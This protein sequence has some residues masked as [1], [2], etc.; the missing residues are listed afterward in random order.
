MFAQIHRFESS[1]SEEEKA[2]HFDYIFTEK[3]DQQDIF[4]QTTEPLISRVLEGAPVTIFCYGAI[5]S[6]TICCIFLLESKYHF[7]NDSYLSC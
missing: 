2:F 6:G 5:A 3:T 1:S 4:L 7:D